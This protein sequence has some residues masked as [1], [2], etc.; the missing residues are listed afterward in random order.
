MEYKEYSSDMYGQI[1]KIYTSASALTP[2]VN[3]EGDA[4]GVVKPVTKDVSEF[5]FILTLGLI[6]AILLFV[7]WG[8][9]YVTSWNKYY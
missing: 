3:A 5:T 2:G 7:K 4:G 1:P 8:D 9:V 6:V